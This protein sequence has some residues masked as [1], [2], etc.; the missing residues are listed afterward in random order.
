MR[1]RRLI[2]LA[3]AKFGVVVAILLR[4]RTTHSQFV[5]LLNPNDTD[6]CDFLK[7]DRTVE[8]LRE[9]SLII[10]DK[11]PMAKRFVIEMVDRNLRDIMDNTKKFGGKVIVFGGDFRQMLLVVPH[12]TRAEIVNASFAKFYLWS[13]M[14]ILK[15]T[16]KY[17]SKNG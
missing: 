10:W 8:L 15:L 1:S 3:T 16:K 2:A 17:E 6:F 5:L 13:K 14:E 9:A 7:K 11:A 12:G 4:D